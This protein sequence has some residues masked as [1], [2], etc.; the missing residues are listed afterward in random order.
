MNT[1]IIS[2]PDK[3][4]NAL[5]DYFREHNIDSFMH[6]EPTGFAFFLKHEG[7]EVLVHV[8]LSATSVLLE[9]A[10][11]GDVKQS[12]EECRELVNAINCESSLT[13]VVIDPDSEFRIRT[14]LFFGE[15]ACL[16]SQL[17]ALATLHFEALEQIVPLIG[18]FARGELNL[19]ECRNWIALLVAMRDAEPDD[20]KPPPPRLTMLPRCSLN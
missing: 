20:D 15:G 5:R 2:E 19:D 14:T 12:P 10:L 3:I 1:T 13:R 7:T 4:L 6:E 8:A 16:E 17:T 18:K 9:T 11:V